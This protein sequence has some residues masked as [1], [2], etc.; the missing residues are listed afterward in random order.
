MLIAW[1]CA[2]EASWPS[3]SAY[4]IRTMASLDFLGESDSVKRCL[5]TDTSCCRILSSSCF[6]LHSPML[7]LEG[8]GDEG[9][10]GRELS[11]REERGAE[12]GAEREEL[13]ER[14]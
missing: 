8:G 10:T 13:R 12:R 3:I 4:I 5:S 7:L 6:D 11:E 9:H 14:S 1:M 2:N